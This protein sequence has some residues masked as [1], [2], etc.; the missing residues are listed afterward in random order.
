L[1]NAIED[2]A[3]QVGQAERG[4]H[5]RIHPAGNLPEIVEVFPGE[6]DRLQRIRRC[7]SSFLIWWHEAHQTAPI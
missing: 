7:G 3:D 1:F 2:R 4:R 6:G 5:V